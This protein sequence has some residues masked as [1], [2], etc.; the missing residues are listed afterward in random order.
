MRGDPVRPGLRG[1][2]PSSGRKR[3]PPVRSGP[4]PRPWG[5]YG[6]TTHRRD[7][8]GQVSVEF[9]G[10]L[11]ILLILGFAVLQLGIA[12]YTVQQT[13][14]A[15]RSAARTAAHDDPQLAYDEAGRQSVSSWLADDSDFTRTT[16]GDDVTVTAQLTIPSVVPGIGDFGEVERSSTMP[17]R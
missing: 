10:F 2:S 4:V 7:Q 6:G 14:T 13:G 16:N 17:L 9:L 1:V 5:R 11:P 3:T 12:A 8:R 15:A